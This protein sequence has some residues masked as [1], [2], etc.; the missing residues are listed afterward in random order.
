MAQGVPRQAPHR[1]LVRARDALDGPGRAVGVPEVDGGVVAAGR[2]QGVR[3]RMP[4]Q[5]RH[6]LLVSLE[7][8]PHAHGPYIHQHHEL[9]P[10]A[11][12]Q[13]LAIRTPH[14]ARNGVLVAKDCRDGLTGTGIPK[15]DLRVLRASRHEAL[16]GVPV[17]ALHVPAVACEG[18][19][20]LS[21]AEVPDLGVGVVCAG[22]ELEAGGRDGDVANGLLVAL[23][24][25]EVVEVRIPELDYAKLVT[26]HKDRLLRRPLHRAHGSIVCLHDVLEVELEG[27]PDRDLACLRTTDQTP[28]IGKPVHDIH[29]GAV[30]VGGGVDKPATDRVIWTLRRCK[31]WHQLLGVAVVALQALR[32]HTPPQAVL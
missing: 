19:L 16:R 23:K 22:A 21:R 14:D 5:R 4:A 10:R 32:R 31:W 7:D 26:T 2:E 29:R 1:A 12:C 27:I 28:P 24:S 18:P 25:L 8:L 20:L 17:A 9:V 15:L 13:P 3:L 11:T 6:L 30:L